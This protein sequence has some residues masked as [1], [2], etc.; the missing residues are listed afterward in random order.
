MAEEHREL[1]VRL[2]SQDQQAESDRQDPRVLLVSPDHLVSQEKRVPVV[3]VEIMGPLEEKEKEDQ[4]DRLEAQETKGTE[5]RMDPRVLTAL[6]AQLELQDREALWDFLVRGESAACWDFQDP[7][8]LQGNREPQELQ[9]TKVRQ[10][11][12]AQQEP[13]VLVEMLVLMG[14]LDLTDRQARTEF[15]E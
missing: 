5:E 15:W 10:V 14:L 9:E 13:M 4:L 6:Q 7:R 8:V 11:L 2:V 1:Q 3:S 12:S